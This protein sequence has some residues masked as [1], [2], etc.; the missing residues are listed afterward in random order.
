MSQSRSVSMPGLLVDPNPSP[1]L[2]LPLQSD[3]QIPLQPR[4]LLPP[5]DQ[6]D[7][8][9]RTQIIQPE[10]FQLTLRV[11]AVEVNVVEIGVRPAIFVHQREG[12]TGDVFLGSR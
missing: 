5:L 9:L 11:D 12:G 4:K 10:R 8:V 3:L 1:I 2:A 6:Q 7:A